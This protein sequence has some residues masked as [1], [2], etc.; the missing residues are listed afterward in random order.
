[1]QQQEM[2]TWMAGMRLT[3]TKQRHAGE[4]GYVLDALPEH[5]S[6][7]SAGGKVAP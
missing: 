5:L 7:H 2:A 3:M 4:H 1:M 6:V